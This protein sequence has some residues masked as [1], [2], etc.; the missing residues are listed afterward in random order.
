MVCWNCFIGLIGLM[1]YEKNPVY[2]AQY[3]LTTA[4]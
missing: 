2:F 4:N 1:G 3:V